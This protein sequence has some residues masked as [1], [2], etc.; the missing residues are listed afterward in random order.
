MS[1]TVVALAGAARCAVHCSNA[2]LVGLGVSGSLGSVRAQDPVSAA[3]WQILI[4]KRDAKYTLPDQRRHF[5]L[6]QLRAPFVMKA[7]RKA[8]DHANRTIRC[9]EQQRTRV[10]G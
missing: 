9:G 8:I 7:G 4:P 6:D 1:R 5:V 10:R 3:G 2:A